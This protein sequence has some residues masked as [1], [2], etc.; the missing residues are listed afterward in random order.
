[1]GASSGRWP[2]WVERLWPPPREVRDDR[3]VGAI[4]AVVNQKGG[5]GK[6][7]VTLGLA[8]AAMARKD[9]VLIVDADPQ[10]NATWA[11]GVD[12]ESVRYGT[13]EAIEA[14]SSG[15]AANGVVAS[16][17]SDLVHVLPASRSLQ[18]RDTETG[19]KR[20]ARRL[21]VALDGV[22]DAYELVVVDCSPALGPLTTNAL[23][24]A[25]LALMVVEPAAL[26]ARGIAGVSDLVDEV[27]ERFN[28]RLDIAGVIVNRVPPV[29]HEADRQHE[30]LVRMLGR[31][32][33]WSPEIPQRVVV[34]EA[35]GLRS[36]IHTTGV[37]GAEIAA[38]FDM[39]YAKLRR[40]GRKVMADRVTP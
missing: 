4:V 13:A 21:R 1:M 38:M 22:A 5:V 29:S 34:T 24:A 40:M 16:P 19:K 20:L 33:V 36:P 30:L 18:D 12:P 26:S 3:R 25:D 32:T 39:H 23:A 35:L 37:R 15:A 2:A 27:W 31:S 10:A 11:L 6:T 9:R 8:S 14:D 28:D 7:T 17:W